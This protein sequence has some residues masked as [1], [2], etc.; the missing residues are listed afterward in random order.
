MEEEIVSESYERRRFLVVYPCRLRTD[1]P[2]STAH[3]KEK[4]PTL[5]HRRPNKSF[6]PFIRVIITADFRH[7]SLCSFGGG[8]RRVQGSG[9]LA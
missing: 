4:N 7:R 8:P 1:W 9:N 5:H 3:R 6:P 2:S